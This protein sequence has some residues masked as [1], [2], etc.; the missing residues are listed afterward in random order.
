L[1]YKDYYAILGVD[2]S[3]SQDDIQKTYRKLARKF[4]PDVNKDP[5]A[6][7]KFKEM[8]EAYEVLKDPEKRKK[9][10]QF[11]SAWNRAQQTGGTPPGFEGFDFRGFGGGGGAGAGGAGF[12]SFF[13]MLFG[14]GAGPEAERASGADARPTTSLGEPRGASGRSKRSHS[15]PQRRAATLG[16]SRGVR[17]GRRST[18]RGR[19]PRTEGRTAACCSRSSSP[20]PAS[21]WRARHPTKVRALGGRPGEAEAEVETAGRVRVRIPPAPPGARSAARRG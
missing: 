3:A 12:S 1:D 9:Y 7:E 20:D 14:S 16:P 11:G 13:D 18:S 4:H 6:E 17:P 2:K 8:G 21:R 19:G 10:D 15:R 5:K